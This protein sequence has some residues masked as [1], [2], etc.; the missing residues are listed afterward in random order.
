MKD[1]PFHVPTTSKV[2]E[3]VK[4]KLHGGNSYEALVRL[5]GP[6]VECEAFVNGMSA[7][8]QDTSASDTSDSNQ[9]GDTIMEQRQ[10]RFEQIPQTQS[11]AKDA[12]EE[13]NKIDDEAP[14]PLQSEPQKSTSTAANARETLMKDRFRKVRPDPDSMY[15]VGANDFDNIVL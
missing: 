4:V 15:N 11:N 6:K 7:T 8:E 10:C 14:S 12:D 13:A 9:S 5:L 1:S 3:N 2:G